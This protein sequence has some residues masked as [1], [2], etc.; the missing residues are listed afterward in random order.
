MTRIAFVFPGQGSQYIGMGK[1]LLS[2]SHT[3]EM[4]EEANEILGRDLKD[5][6]LSGPEE[7]L[8]KTKNTQTAV[9]VI[10]CICLEL[11]KKSGI[12]PD[13]VAGHS[14]GE[15]TALVAAELINYE[16]GLKLMSRRADLMQEAADKRPGAM[17]AVLGLDA[18]DIASVID[19][20]KNEG[21]INI[22]NYNCPG[23]VVISGER[24]LIKKAFGIFEDLGAKRVVLLPVSGAFHTEMMKE[25]EDRLRVDIEQLVFKEARIPV[26]SN[27]N[28]ESSRDPAKI[29]EAL[30]QQM[31][32]SVLWEQSINRIL[33]DNTEIFVEVG[34]GRIL[35]GLIRRISRDVRVLNVED[36]KTLEKIKAT[37]T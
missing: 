13:I 3:A 23:Q 26:V 31:T 27:S 5:I 6:C 12:K 9:F 36:A 22:A 2:F 29:K 18:R 28:A 33:A 35:T 16:Q 7:E 32:S 34:P 25:A 20:I 15:Y 11:I 4:L 37:L 24:T 14:L 1:E 10:S 17:A 30:E 21:A 19:G 8:R